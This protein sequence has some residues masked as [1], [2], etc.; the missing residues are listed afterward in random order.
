VSDWSRRI[1][2]LVCRYLKEGRCLKDRGYFGYVQRNDK[3]CCRV[4]DRVDEIVSNDGREGKGYRP[5]LL[6]SGKM[7]R[8][9]MIRQ[10]VQ[11]RPNSKSRRIGY[12]I[13]VVEVLTKVPWSKHSDSSAT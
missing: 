13:T 3:L 7:Y 8:H 2:R 9:E 11:Y 12:G 6:R 4:K 5:S 1:Y 10:Y